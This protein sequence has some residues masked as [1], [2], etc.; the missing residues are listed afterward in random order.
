MTKNEI[1]NA[2]CKTHLNMHVRP[3]LKTSKHG[4]GEGGRF[5]LKKKNCFKVRPPMWLNLENR[6]KI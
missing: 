5:E 6:W 2:S 4:R 3:Y 1:E